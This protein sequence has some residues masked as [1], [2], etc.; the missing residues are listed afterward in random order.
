MT[1]IYS[2]S[3]SL[4]QNLPAHFARGGW[5]S[6]LGLNL[7]VPDPSRLFEGSEGLDFPPVVLISVDRVDRNQTLFEF[8]VEREP[9]PGPIF[10]MR[11]QSALDGVHVHVL[12][13]LDF[14]LQTPH[15]EVV[16][17]P[18]PETRQRIY[19]AVEMK[20]QLPGAPGWASARWVLSGA[21]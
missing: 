12:Q 20:F 2:S 19:G 7:R 16:E 1:H 10:G 17:T 3:H 14:L 5:R 4:S 9:A 13:L 15:V 11:H 18:L 21:S 8:R 6:L